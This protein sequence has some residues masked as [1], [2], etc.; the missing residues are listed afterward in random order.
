MAT[1]FYIFLIFTVFN[2]E[3]IE[4]RCVNILN[5]E[6]TH[7]ATPLNLDETS[8][9]EFYQTDSEDPKF[10][11]YLNCVWLKWNYVD[12]DGVILYS[13]LIKSD[14]LPWQISRICIKSF[15]EIVLNKEETQ[16]ASPLN[17]NATSVF[18]FYETYPN[19][20]IF[21]QYLNCMWLKW[22]YMNE[23]G[24]IL[25]H[26]LIT[27]DNLPRNIMKLRCANFLSEVETQCATPLN[28]NAT[29]VIEFYQADSEDQKFVQYLNCVWLK[30]NYVN[31]NGVIIYR[32]LI[33]SDSLPWQI[34]RFCQD[35]VQ[36][37]TQMRID[38]QKAAK[39]CKKNRPS[40]ESPFTTK[41]RC[42]NPL[43]EK[44]QECATPLNLDATSIIELY[45]ADSE[46]L[47]FVQYLNCVWLKLDYIDENGVILYNNLINSNDLPWQISRICHDVYQ[48]LLQLISDYQE[49]A[50]HCEQNPPKVENPMT[51]KRC[52]AHNYKPTVVNITIK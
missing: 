41:S 4:S 21:A 10:G 36:Y 19:S 15:C 30:W 52:I 35:V 9:L 5:K 37:I 42:G 1:K 20:T 12:K 6:E 51:V 50:K 17:L 13:N 22:N 27:S 28:L 18:K 38:F 47:T 24:V 11:E 25:Y 8:V 32:N 14:N 33:K 26:N 3:Q 31:K 7:C 29:S 39:Y 48:Y 44:E 23:N 45:R 2:F 43:S 34:S 40:V 46:D 49:A 16:C